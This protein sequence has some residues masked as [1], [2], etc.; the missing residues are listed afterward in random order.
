MNVLISVDMEGISGVVSRRETSAGG[1]PGS[2]RGEDYERARQWMTADT[3]AAVEGAFRGGATRVV[4]ADSHGNMRNL[5]FDG[6]DPRAEL[7]RGGWNRPLF[8]VEGLDETFA[9]VLLVGS[10]ARAGDA[11][12]ILAHTY[13]SAVLAEVRING[14]PIS[15]AMFAAGLA[16]RHGVPV[17]LVTGDDVICADTKAR[18]P[19]VETAVVKYAIDRYIARCLPQPVAHQRIR[20]GA[21]RA[22]ARIGEMRPFQFASPIKLEVTTIDASAAARICFIPQIKR[23]SECTVSYYAQDV[24]EAHDMFMACLLLALTSS[25]LGV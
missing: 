23:E 22:L 19:H 16:G 3:N 12:G 1:T 7:V 5:L 24:Q 15:E 11:R 6:L 20:E 18:L 25:T 9:A 4:V 2:S 13:S 21:E 10:H 14:E 17:A 8:T